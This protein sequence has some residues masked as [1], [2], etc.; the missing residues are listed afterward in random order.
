M[1]TT[2]REFV[3][4]TATGAALAFLPR[5]TW[6]RAQETKR[7]FANKPVREKL[8]VI[9]DITS[10]GN[11]LMVPTNAGPIIIDSKFAHT[12]P[13]LHADIKSLTG[14]APT[15]LINT[16]HHADHSGGNWIFHETTRIVAHKNFNSRIEGNLA[17]YTQQAQNHAQEL[18]EK[19]ADESNQ[20]QAAQLADRIKSMKSDQFKAGTELPDGETIITHG[21]VEM[22]CHHFGNGHT[23]NDVV[24]FFPKQNVMHMGDLLF[25]KCF[26]FIDR[27]A[28]ANTRSWQTVLKKCME[29]GDDDT[30]VIPG[31][32]EITEKSALERQY[33][34]F[35]QMRDV[36]SKA[37]RAEKTKEEVMKIEP[38]QYA[39]YQLQ[40]IRPIALGAMYDELQEDSR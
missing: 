20:N 35:N 27:K 23:D 22:R 7:N 28:K 13:A 8:L 38:E 15:M 11:V 12:A 25:H 37:V 31:H 14:N 21:N 5:W 39:D 29:L 10:G 26:P 30:I 6:A 32:G 36:V 2:R 33:D 40:F 1:R 9:G 3:F 17:Q 19:N 16:H 34:F 24:I 18:K 4:A